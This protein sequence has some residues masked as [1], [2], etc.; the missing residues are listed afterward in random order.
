M[1]L[2]N[3]HVKS[4]VRELRGKC[5]HSCSL[6]HGSRYG[7][8][9]WIS[10]TKLHQLSGKHSCVCHD[11]PVLHDLSCLYIKRIN[12]V[13][14]ARVS[15]GMGITLALH[16][17]HM[18]KDRSVELKRFAESGLHHIYIV[19]VYRSYICDT[20]LLEEHTRHKYLLDGIL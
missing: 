7:C 6:A 13:E 2:R 18:H 12:A 16:S 3:A 8:Y 14:I 10:L 4:P 17:L 20:Q 1:F 5:R 9:P 19:S 15:L 11:L